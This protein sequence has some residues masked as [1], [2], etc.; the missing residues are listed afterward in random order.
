MYY[1]LNFRSEFIDFIFCIPEQTWQFCLNALLE[2]GFLLLRENNKDVVD[3]CIPNEFE[4]HLD[5][6]LENERILLCR[7]V[8]SIHLQNF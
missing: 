4:V 5:Y 1:F 7:Q 2:D 6:K 3:E 8:K